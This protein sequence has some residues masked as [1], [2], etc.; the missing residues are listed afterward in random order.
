MNEVLKGAKAPKDPTKKRPGF[1]IMKNK[2]ICGSPQK[3]GSGIQFIYENDGRMLDA[4]KLVG[5][6]T[7][8][9]IINMLK[10][11]DSFKKLVH[12]I[13]VS[14]ETDDRE[15][16]LFA[17]QMYGKKDVYG[18]GTTLKMQV[19]GDGMEYI[20][21]L[22]SVDWSDDDNEPG[23]IR[24]E[25]KKGGDLG[26]ATVRFY[27]RDGFSVPKEEEEN[28][29][30]FSS[31]SY[32]EMI[33]NSLMHMGNTARINRVY[34]RAK[35]GKDVTLAF[36]G[37]SI[38]QGAGAIPINKE[39]YARKIFE[40]FCDSLNVS[41]DSNVHYVKAGVGGTPSELGM[42]R[43]ERDV[44][45][46][47]KV[48]PDLVVIE[49]AVND[50]G[51]ETHGECFDSLTRK[52]YNGPGNPAVI[53]LY[54]VFSD[55]NNLQDRLS[56]VGLAYDIPMVSVKDA[57]VP[58]FYKKDGRVLS[59]NQYFYDRYHPNNTGHRIM[60]DCVLN[61]IFEAV[62]NSDSLEKS[63][64]G[65]TPPIGGEFENVILFDKKDHTD[66]AVV[67]QG[68]FTDTDTVL[69]S[70]EQD[71]NLTQTPM[72]P[73]NWYYKGKESGECEPFKLDVEATALLIIF[74]DSCENA[75]GSASVFVD[76]AK[77]LTLD[78]K[79]VGW[80]HCNPT[81]IFRNSELKKRH[82]EV[83]VD[84]PTKNF[85]ILGFGICK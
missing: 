57:V 56:P 74:K 70:V 5:N 17:F 35:E 66:L 28:P 77:V 81:I 67:E 8:E 60:A 44:L 4:A 72:F 22:D 79:I 58:E 38:T 68:S 20:L 19:P 64:N 42:L 83:K 33:S 23:Q 9:S 12:S 2:S 24:F 31:I 18:S 39:C 82:I 55:D 41:Y 59:K 50:E 47:G 14:V 37:G 49:F 26:K 13:G 80:T 48:T 16:V 25:L 3:D 63:I 52:I 62:R 73:Y 34:Q 54:S 30:D 78:P 45:K 7:D 75:D 40:G 32:K 10:K 43:Y 61:L 11:T 85:T 69:Q 71:M 1:C 15:E 27:V 53:L 46:N 84:D 76:G 65:I 6:I 51:D 29:V 21:E 36:I